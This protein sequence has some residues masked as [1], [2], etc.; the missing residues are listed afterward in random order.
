MMMRKYKSL[1]GHLLFL[2]P[3]SIYKKV[4]IQRVIKAESRILSDL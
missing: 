2:F 1:F 3:L 4:L